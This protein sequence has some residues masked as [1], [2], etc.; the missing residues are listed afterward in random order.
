MKIAVASPYRENSVLSIATGA[1]H[2]GVLDFF[3]TTLYAGEWATRTSTLPFVGQRLSRELSRRGFTSIPQ[4]QVCSVASLAEVTRIAAFRLSTGLLDFPGALMY[5]VKNRFDAAVA[6]QLIKCPVDAV[7]GMWGSCSQ[8]FEAVDRDCIKVLN[9]VNSRPRCHNEYL[10]RYADLRRGNGEVLS[11]A[12]ERNVEKEMRLADIILVPSVFIAEQMRDYANKVVMQPYGVD[13]KQFSPG[14]SDSRFRCNVLTVGQIAYRKGFTTLIE[15]ARHLPDYTFHAVGP[16]VVPSLLK[17]LPS[18]LKYAGLVMHQEVAA[19]MRSADVFV[20]PSF[21]DAFPLVTLEAMASGTPVIISDHAGTSEVV[22]E[23]ATGHVFEA[24]N[25]GQLASCITQIVENPSVRERMSQSARAAVV[26][27]HSW[28]DYSSAVLD[29][30]LKFKNQP[31][32]NL[33]DTT[34]SPD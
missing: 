34:R 6:K 33:Y 21:E 1:S 31:I 3:Y 20:L 12:V 7:V 24:G 19:V 18:N 30:I 4:N 10:F 22:E 8:T 28:D 9:F 14:P 32:S 13:L 23:G 29:A 5:W 2:R 16:I 25:V 27:S 26:A 15:V 17:A 11:A